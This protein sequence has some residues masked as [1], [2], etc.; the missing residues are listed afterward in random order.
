VDGVWIPEGEKV[1]LS[2]ASGN[3]DPRRWSN[4]DKFDI[5]RNNAGHLGFG[6]GVH[7]CVGQML[8][9]L[10]GEVVLSALVSRV[11]KIELEAEPK[12]LLSNTSRGFESIPVRVTPN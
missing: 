8:A 9:R 11:S 10:Q 4:A 6:T 5:R 2:Y 1:Y 7:R 12:I 3:R